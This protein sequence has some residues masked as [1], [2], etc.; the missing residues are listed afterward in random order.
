MLHEAFLNQSINLEYRTNDRKQAHNEFSCKHEFC[1]DNN[2]NRSINLQQKMMR[3][4]FSFMLLLIQIIK[5]ELDFKKDNE[6]YNNKLKR[7]K[8][9]RL[10]IYFKCQVH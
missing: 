5:S 6:E 3:T 9:K 10:F 7:H 2:E 1:N 8:I 4:K